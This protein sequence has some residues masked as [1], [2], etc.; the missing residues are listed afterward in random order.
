MLYNYVM[1]PYE[2]F[3]DRINFTVG[4]GKDTVILGTDTDG[5]GTNTVGLG[6]Y[7]VFHV[8]KKLL[9]INAEV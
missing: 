4:L 8:I 2:P 5:M 6:T 7:I 3:L 9:L 1:V